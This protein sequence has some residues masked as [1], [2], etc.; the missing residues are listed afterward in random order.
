MSSTGELLS[1]LKK[2]PLCI[3]LTN[4]SISTQMLCAHGN[5]RW[6]PH[7]ADVPFSHE[8]LYFKMQLKRNTLPWCII[9]KPAY[10]VR[11]MEWHIIQVRFV[12][13][14]ATVVSLLLCILKYAKI[15][16]EGFETLHQI[17][18]I[19]VIKILFRWWLVVLCTVNTIATTANYICYLFMYLIIFC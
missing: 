18:E 12:I 1:L 16:V 3:F 13:C 2:I 6:H 11:I 10:I 4:Y 17:L 9:H 8:G 19:F 15:F 7:I 5:L 14:P